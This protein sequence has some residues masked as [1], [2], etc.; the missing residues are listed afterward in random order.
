MRINMNTEVNS[1]RLLIHGFSFG[2]WLARPMS[3]LLEK[4]GHQVHLEPKVMDVLVCLARH[5]GEVVTRDM[6]LDEV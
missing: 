1:E 4:N 2:D 5:Q 6:L 3:G